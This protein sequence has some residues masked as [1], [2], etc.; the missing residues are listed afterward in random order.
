[1]FDAKLCIIM[2]FRL[3]FKDGLVWHLVVLMNNLAPKKKMSWVGGG[4]RYAKLDPRLSCF[5]MHAQLAKY[6]KKRINQLK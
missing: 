6:R 2:L 1:M 3:I 5:N 4:A